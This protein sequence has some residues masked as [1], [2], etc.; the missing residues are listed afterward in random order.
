MTREVALTPASEIPPYRPNW[1][2]W[3]LRAG[4]L[5]LEAW[6]EKNCMYYVDLEECL[7]SADVLDHIA[8][9]SSKRAEP[10]VMAGLVTA[11]D[12][13]LNLQ[14]NLCPYGSDSPMTRAD[15]AEMVQRAVKRWPHLVI[16]DETE[17]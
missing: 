17:R 16:V 10:R 9:V 11:L 7:T 2:P 8:Q 4:N 3:F 6:P 12:D 13:V 1:G 5:M 14:G 15:V